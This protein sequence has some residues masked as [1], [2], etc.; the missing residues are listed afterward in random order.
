MT[1]YS[2][3]HRLVNMSPRTIRAWQKDE[4]ARCASQ[5][6]TIGRL[7]QL[8]ALKGK[9]RSAW[10]PADERYARKVIGFIRR[11]EARR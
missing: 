8:A 5:L 7:A 10:T 4:R 6:A 11:H 2:D 3:F 1:V 9:R